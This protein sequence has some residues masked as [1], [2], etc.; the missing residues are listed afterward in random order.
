MTLA[1]LNLKSIL[2]VQS[3]G[4][5]KSRDSHGGIKSNTHQSLCRSVYSAITAYKLC[6]QTC[7]ALSYL[8]LFVVSITLT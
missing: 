7:I 1:N 4:S 2:L 5:N 3:E 6:N 8:I